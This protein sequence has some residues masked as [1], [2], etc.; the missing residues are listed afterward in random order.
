M[1]GSP[2][3]GSTPV[4]SPWPGVADSASGR[5]C[6]NVADFGSVLNAATSRF[7]GD[8]ST[9]VRDYHMCRT[10]RALF[11]QHPPGTMFEDRYNDHKHRF[12]S[13]PVGELLFT[14]GSS[15]TNAYQLADRISEDI[16]LSVALTTE[17]EAKNARGRIRR[18]AVTDA[19]RAC[20]PELPDDAHNTRTTGGDVGRR[21]ITMGDAHNYLVAESS[22]IRP[23]DE[24]LQAELDAACGRPFVV[25]RV[26]PCQSLM[27]RAA[28]PTVVD[29]YPDLAAFELTALC[30]PF[31][32]ANKFLAL[33]KRAM[34]EEPDDHALIELQKRGRDIYDLWSIAQSPAHAAETR[35]T[36]PILARHIQA[37]GATKEPH[38]RPDAGFSTSLAFQPGTPQYQALATGYDAVVTDLVWGRRPASFDDAVSTIKTLDQPPGAAPPPGDGSTARSAAEATRA[39][40]RD[41]GSAPLPNEETRPVLHGR[42]SLRAERGHDLPNLHHDAA[43]R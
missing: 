40:G 21:V 35:A 37:K 3:G 26:V 7:V 2:H 15:L 29:T 42:A 17:V 36:L 16:D 9:I 34:A 20:S 32:A 30:V 6:D 38:P 23:F 19:A 14:G 5:L 18:L 10:L 43:T 28:D 22:I 41:A 39:D 4:P 1:T 24:D 27:G 33:H 8:E 25:A 31:T 12:V 11:T 13:S